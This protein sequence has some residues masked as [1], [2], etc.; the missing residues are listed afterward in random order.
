[1]KKEFKIEIS[2]ITLNIIIGGLFSLLV[3]SISTLYK[4]NTEIT[5]QTKKYNNNYESQVL[6]LK[7]LTNYYHEVN[8]IHQRFRLRLNELNKTLASIKLISDFNQINKNKFSKLAFTK[9][10]EVIDDIKV[11]DSQQEITFK[12]L[13]SDELNKSL[14]ELLKQESELWY[15]TRDLFTRTKHN[16]DDYLKLIEE[17]EKKLRH[18]DELFNRHEANNL[19]Y[20]SNLNNQLLKEIDVLEKIKE[21]KKETKSIRILAFFGVILCLILTILLLK[22]TF[23]QI[24]KR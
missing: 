15:S 22:L 23:K 2:K 7:L 19:K 21:Q 18:Y 12:N 1:M 20:N 24:N 5:A 6:Q 3:I 9:L 4:S 10:N 11:I 16:S 8:I 14:I 13:S 17:I